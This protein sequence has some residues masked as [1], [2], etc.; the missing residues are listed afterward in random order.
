MTDIH[1]H[2]K[3][4]RRARELTQEAV[5]RQ[6]G[7]TRQAVSSHESGRTQPD[8]ETLA[9]YGEVYGVSLQEI[10]YGGSRSERQLRRLRRAAWTVGAVLPICNALWAGLRW[11]ASRFFPIQEGQMQAGMQKVW[12]QHRLLAELS[13]KAEGLSLVIA[14]LAVVVLA[15]LALRL[16]RPVPLREKLS[17]LGILTALAL[18]AVLPFALADPVFGL[19]DYTVTPLRQILWG[20]MAVLVLLTVDALRGRKTT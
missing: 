15:V 16:E 2:L 20:A 6:V 11:T 8:L 4:L 12:E 13:E 7:L 18:A 5:A 14:W 3:A 1:S 10:L 9:R 19:A 17:C